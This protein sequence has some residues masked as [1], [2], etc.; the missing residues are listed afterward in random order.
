MLA[1]AYGVIADVCPPAER[2]AMQGFATGGANLATCLG[3]V[4]GGWVAFGGGVLLLV[5]M[6]L[7]ETARS[8]VGNGSVEV[9][10]WRQTWWSV[11]KR[12]KKGHYGNK[13][14]GDGTAG[15]TYA[16]GL[17]SGTRAKFKMPNPWHC[18]RMLFWKDTAL[19]LW[20]SSSPYAVWYCVQA[21]IPLIYQDIYGF[22][23]LQVGLTYLTGATGVVL[24]S[25]L[26]G[27]MMD[28]N[29]RVTA[30]SIGHS[31]DKVSG[32]NLDDFQSREL[33]QRAHTIS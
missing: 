4:I 25:Y 21:S 28:R 27:R 2:G 1:V 33:G 6:A 17:N 15:S 22:N 10:V 24:G 20:L 23:E 3:P 18:L 8:V 9:K 5:G 30:R 13:E 7:P 12:T 31:I 26:N 14:K 11:L 16:R 32:D 29:Y 19:V